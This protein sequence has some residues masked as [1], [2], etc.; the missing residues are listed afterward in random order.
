MSR[1]FDDQE[2]RSAA[3]RARDWAERLPQ[4]AAAAQGT[5]AGATRLAGVDPASITS[6]EDLAGLPVLRKSDLVE[7]QGA[8][9]P[10]GGLTAVPA[11]GFAHVF[12]SPGPIYEPGQR[13]RDWWRMGRFL[14]AAG[15]GDGD[16]VQNCFSYHMTPAG[17]IFENGAAAVGATV[18]PAGTGQTDQQVAAAAGNMIELNQPV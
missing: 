13:S 3:A 11:T 2:T 8:N 16:V 9:A 14:S 15:V 5:S 6:A 1:Y 17:M 7:L 18:F 4:V 12:Q 10:F